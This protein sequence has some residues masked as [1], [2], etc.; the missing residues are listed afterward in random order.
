ME[1]DS[2]S[3]TVKSFCRFAGIG[4]SAAVSLLTFMQYSV[5]FAGT[6]PAR[7]NPLRESQNSPRFYFF[8]SLTLFFCIMRDFLKVFHDHLYL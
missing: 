3:S 4:S 1:C 2:V 8:F 5:F 7:I 6:E